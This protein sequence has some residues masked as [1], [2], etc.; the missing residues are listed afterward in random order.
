MMTAMLTIGDAAPPFTLRDQDGAS[1]SLDD[2]RGS[3]V[4]LW[5]YPKA[6]TPG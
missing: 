3:W 2:L 5:W 4:L 1:V 6:A